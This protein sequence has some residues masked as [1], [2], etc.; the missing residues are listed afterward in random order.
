MKVMRI[1]VC[2]CWLSTTVFGQ[3]SP[4]TM[5]KIVARLDAPKVTEGSFA[6][7]PKAMYRAGTRYCRIEES[8][9][10]E[11]GIH[12]LIIFN[13]PD[14]WLINLL[15]KTGKHLTDPGPTFNCRLPI[16]VNVEDI[17][18]AADVNKPL[19]GLEFG[20]ERAFFVERGATPTQGPT[21]QG[22]PT[23]VYTVRIADSQL[24]LF[25]NGDSERPVA[26]A[27]QRGN[28]QET[29]W[30]GEYEEIPFDAKLFARPEGVNIEEVR[31]YP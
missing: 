26:V 21:L 14:E 10:N 29:Y 8:S 24:F 19:M 9:D 11:H 12:G 25:T 2:I 16:F 27:R 7:M 6:A 30:F 18:S 20:R 4:P 23:R 13:E 5:T 3:Q 17:K 22:K 1:L 28:T 15:T 31:P